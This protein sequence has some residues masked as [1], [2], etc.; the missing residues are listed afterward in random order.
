MD[1]PVI[2]ADDTVKYPVSSVIE[3]I[4]NIANSLGSNL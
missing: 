2:Y 4:V 1:D 3:D